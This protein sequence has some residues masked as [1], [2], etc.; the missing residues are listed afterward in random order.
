M[1]LLIQIINLFEINYIGLSAI[2]IIIALISMYIAENIIGFAV[3]FT[4][5]IGIGVYYSIYPVWV[6]YLS[7]MIVIAFIPFSNKFRLV[8]QWRI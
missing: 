5:F 3:V 4:L 7:V 2:G 1:S 8:K 6:L